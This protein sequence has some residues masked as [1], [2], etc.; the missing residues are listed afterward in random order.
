MQQIDINSGLTD[1]LSEPAH[2]ILQIDR[3]SAYT[4]L[5]WHGDGNL[6]ARE[7][8]RVLKPAELVSKP[9]VSPSDADALMAGLWLWHDW[10]DESHTISQSIETESG[11]F[12]HGIMHRREGDFSNAKYWYARCRNHPVLRSIGQ[13]ANEIL[14]PLPADKS[15]FR[16][17][18]DGWHPD[19]FVD[20]VEAMH[21][22]PEDARFQAAVA[23]QRLEWRLLFDYCMRRATGQ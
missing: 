15:L 4:R 6:A 17:V 22:K 16:L 23:L 1:A 18:R 5:T 7:K 19:A 10:L 2:Q 20:L 3:E 12:W 14:H 21:R 9:V 11:S 13:Y 8:L